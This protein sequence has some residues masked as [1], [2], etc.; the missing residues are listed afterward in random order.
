MQK[1][2]KMYRSDSAFVANFFLCRS[3]NQL[4]FQ[5]YDIVSS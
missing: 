5:G 2:K 4:S 3:S 1:N